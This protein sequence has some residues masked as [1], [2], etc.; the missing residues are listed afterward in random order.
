M[1]PLFKNEKMFYEKYLELKNKLVFRSKKE[2][3][4]SLSSEKIG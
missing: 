4:P 1:E 3:S 2:N